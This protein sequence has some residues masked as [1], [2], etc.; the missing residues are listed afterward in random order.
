MAT[1]NAKRRRP[2]K[3]RTATENT[4]APPERRRGPAPVALQT[5]YAAVLDDYTAT[6]QSAPLSDQ[7][8]R[9]YTSKVRQFLAW[10]AGAD[11]DADPLTS[12]DG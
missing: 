11:L 4:T 2:K 1:E 9:T 8:R 6:L 7:T 12:A 5:P 10:L 3:A